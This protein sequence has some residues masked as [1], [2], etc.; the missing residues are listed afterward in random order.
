MGEDVSKANEEAVPHTR[1]GDSQGAVGGGLAGASMWS[2]VLVTEEPERAGLKP[3][4]RFCDKFIGNL[5]NTQVLLLAYALVVVQGVTEEKPYFNVDF[6]MRSFSSFTAWEL[7]IQS[8]HSFRWSKA[9]WQNSISMCGTHSKIPL[10]QI[11]I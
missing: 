1:E 6:R 10:L 4:I 9:G 8:A 3:S 5:N 2:G 7:V 11:R